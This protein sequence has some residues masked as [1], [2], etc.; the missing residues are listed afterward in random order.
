[1][2]SFNRQDV[3]L[4]TNFGSCIRLCGKPKKHHKCFKNVKTHKKK[5]KN[6]KII[7]TRLWCMVSIV[8]NNVSLMRTRRYS[9]HG[10]WYV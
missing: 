4:L 6:K 1:M 3:M 7:T 8:R 5:K 2:G 10:L 9:G